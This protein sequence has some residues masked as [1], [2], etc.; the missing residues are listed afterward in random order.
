MPKLKDLEQKEIPADDPETQEK[1]PIE[2]EE[3]HRKPP[4]EEDFVEHEGDIEPEVFDEDNSGSPKIENKSLVVVDE[5]WIQVKTKELAERLKFKVEALR[6]AAT[7]CLKDPEL[8]TMYKGKGEN[9]KTTYRPTHAGFCKCASVL[10]I[11]YKTTKVDSDIEKDYISYTYET[12]MSF[13]AFLGE[14]LD[15]EPQA[16]GEGEWNSEK[17]MYKYEKNM[18]AIRGNISKCARSQSEVNTFMVL[19]GLKGTTAKDLDNL[20]IDADKIS[21]I[22]FKKK[23]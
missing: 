8:W 1:I 3:G 7:A 22:T 15:K 12:K 18:R 14:G 20:G 21:G 19:M 10:G 13:T 6:I 4:V 11:T 17:P 5:K 16:T 2:R 9:A 23:N